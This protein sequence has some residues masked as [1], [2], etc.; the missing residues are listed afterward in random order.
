MQKLA[1]LILA[2]KRWSPNASTRH[3]LGSRLKRLHNGDIFVATVPR[4]ATS[5]GVCSACIPKGADA[6]RLT[7]YIS[8]LMEIRICIAMSGWEGEGEDLH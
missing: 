6:V 5:V 8:A 7:K 1:R 3:Q 2:T 4:H